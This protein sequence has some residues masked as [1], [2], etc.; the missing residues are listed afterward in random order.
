MRLK[1]DILHL[2]TR[3]DGIKL[4]RFRYIWGGPRYIGVMAQDIL[5][6]HPEAVSVDSQGY[7]LVH[8]DML[9]ITMLELEN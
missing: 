4:Y 1:Q 7:Y 8:Y 9:G 3:P 5:E 6:S 2:Y